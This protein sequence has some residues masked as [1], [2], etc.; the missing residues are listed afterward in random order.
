MVIEDIDN[1]ILH[2]ENKFKKVPFHRVEKSDQQKELDDIYGMSDLDMMHINSGLRITF[3]IH[4]TYSTETW[5]VSSTYI[6]AND[7]TDLKKRFVVTDVD[8][9]KEVFYS[10]ELEIPFAEAAKF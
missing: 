6:Y 2:D 8:F 7:K 1:F 5:K 10:D 9:D 4:E 3:T